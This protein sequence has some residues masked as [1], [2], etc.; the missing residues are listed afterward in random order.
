[1]ITLGTNIFNKLSAGHKET[2]GK[3]AKILFNEV[4][5]VVLNE[6]KE[7]GAEDTE[8]VKFFL[9]NLPLKE[10]VEDVK[11]WDSFGELLVKIFAYSSEDVP[12]MPELQFWITSLSSPL[13]VNVFFSARKKEEISEKILSLRDTFTVSEVFDEK[14]I[15]SGKILIVGYDSE[16]NAWR[17]NHI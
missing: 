2:I 16:G 4:A 1:M 13:P 9:A 11:K 12:G 6:Y 8:Q 15:Q 7:K 14:N 3:D 10:M 17:I 5:D